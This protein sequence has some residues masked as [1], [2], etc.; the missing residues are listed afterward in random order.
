MKRACVSC[1]KV[2]PRSM[3]DV[4]LLVDYFKK[5]GWKIVTEFKEA[6]IILL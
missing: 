5:N 6:D 3:L 1:A 2:C 4:A